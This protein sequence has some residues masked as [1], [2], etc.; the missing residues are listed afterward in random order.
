M[1]AIVRVFIRFYQWTLSPV[2]YLLG[3]AGCRF[4][5]TC[6]EYF[7]QA[8]ETHGV[9][10]GSWLGLKRLAR[11]NPWGGCG[12]DPVPPLHSRAAAEHTICD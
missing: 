7:L 4:Q 8:V 10:H 1:A 2:L 12:Y 5:P 11:C 3:G 6:S 9:M